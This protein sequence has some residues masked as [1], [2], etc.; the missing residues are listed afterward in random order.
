MKSDKTVVECGGAL[1]G[2][3]A[4]RRGEV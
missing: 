4:L 2:V 3:Q 1:G